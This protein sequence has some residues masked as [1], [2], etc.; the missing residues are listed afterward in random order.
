MSHVRISRPDRPVAA[1]RI[2]AASLGHLADSYGIV[3]VYQWCAW[4][5]LLGL[6][7]ALL[8][9]TRGLDR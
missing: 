3:R 5:P 4:L 8:P 2:A 9:G 6:A 1:P 7:T